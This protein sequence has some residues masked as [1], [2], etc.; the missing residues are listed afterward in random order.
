MF[1]INSS[2]IND[3]KYYWEINEENVSS[4]WVNINSKYAVVSDLG[5][6]FNF[7]TICKQ[8]YW[9]YINSH[10]LEDLPSISISKY[11][12]PLRNWWII[13]NKRF[14]DFVFNISI[15]ITSNNIENLEQELRDIKTIFNSKFRLYKQNNSKDNYINVVLTDFSIWN[16][17]LS[18]TDIRMSFLTLDPFWI[19]WN[20]STEFFESLSWELNTTLIIND[21]DY[22]VDLTT[23]IQIKEKTWT[24]NQL[25]LELNWYEIEINQTLNVWDVIVFEWSKNKL[26]I[27]WVETIY[28]W[29][30]LAFPILK[31]WTVKLTYSWWWSL[32]LYNMY[33]LYDKISL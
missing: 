33:I 20:W 14:D 18:W 21:S 5:H 26:Y 16:K 15:T 12:T 2:P 4:F 19:E 22:E 7:S 8:K 24:V 30:I 13:Q 28:K 10:N 9:N 31:P 27:N 23:I 11:E 25:F 32:D 17:L 6:V 3:V 1:E 29:S